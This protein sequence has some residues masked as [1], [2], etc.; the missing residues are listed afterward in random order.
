MSTIVSTQF[1]LPQAVVANGA[2]TGNQWSDPNNILLVDGDV[3]ASNVNQTAS[4]ITIGNFPTNLPQNAVITGLEFELVAKRGAQTNPVITLIPYFL[5]NTSGNDVYYPYVTPITTALTPNLTTILFGGPTYLFASSF[6]PDQINNAKINFIANGDISIDSC[7]MKVYYYV[8]TTPSPLPPVGNSCD[9][10]NSP[11]QA[12]PFYLAL[13]FKAGDQFAYLQSFNYPDG[14]PIQYADL[15]AC[16]GSI[17]LV[18]DPSVPKIGNSNFE[19]NAVIAVWTVLPSGIVQLDFGN[20]NVTR[21]LMF[22]TP[23]T[24]DPTLRSDHDANSKVI[25]SDSAPFLG[26]YLQRCQIDSVVSAPIIIENQ[27]VPLADPAHDIDFRGPGVVTINDPLDSHRKIV[28]IAGNGGTLPPQIVSTTSNTSG[29]TQVITLSALLQISGLNRGVA[30]Q[31]STEQLQTIAS[32]TVGGV[33]ATQKAVSTDVINNL[34][35]ESWF[36]QN[37]PLGSQSVVI[38]L[39][40]AAYISFGAECINGVDP[41]TPVGATQ[42]ASGTSLNP[43][44]SITTTVDYSIV[45]DGLGTAQTPI[46]YTPGAGQGANWHETANADTRQGGS[47]VESA[48]LQPDIIS[49]DYAITQNTP[50]VYTAIEIVGITTITP[51]TGITSLNGDTTAVQTFTPGPGITIVDNGLG[52]HLIS[53]IGGGGGNLIKEDSPHLGGSTYGILTPNPNGIANVFTVASGA[54]VSGNLT[55]WQNGIE[56][57]N[58]SDWVE[59]VPASGTFVIAIPPLVT[60]NLYVE[61]YSPSTIAQTGIQYDVNGVLIPGAVAGATNEVDIAG[62]GITANYVG[63]KTTYTIPT[64]GGAIEKKVGVGAITDIQF[65]NWQALFIPSFWN[66]STSATTPTLIVG[67]GGV[68]P[69]A[70]LVSPLQDVGGAVTDSFLRFNTGKQIII[71]GDIAYDVASSSKTYWGL[72]SG[73]A[74]NNQQGT[75]DMGVAFC[76]DAVGNFFARTSTTVGFTETA[77]ASLINKHSILRIEYD[78]ANATPQARFYVDGVLVATNTTDVPIANTNPIEFSMGNNTAIISGAIGQLSAPSF[79][80]EI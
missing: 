9:D 32:V 14:T 64:G 31:I 26:Q 38:T 45:I 11:I 72:E 66:L 67:N 57:E 61:Y 30:I 51:G 76:S 48:G 5:D 1:L 7:L 59:L 65:Y 79:A 80:I 69:T 62:A 70:S 50:W 18:F 40:G 4:D 12:Q 53:A 55:V 74:A 19:E 49:M 10:C 46:L 42:N 77:I 78:P 23:Y 8:P 36:C 24:A 16:G 39:S 28:T 68:T 58:G 44:L 75:I 3:A 37:P 15:G 21:G 41:I 25:I 2:V 13:P 47:S 34:R 60:D 33:L 52:D 71:Q 17:K 6:T 35:Q 73:N 20:I 54:Y 22:H 63:G 43:N 29:N 27:D 56:L